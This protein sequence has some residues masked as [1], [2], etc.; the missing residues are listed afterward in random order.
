M[1]LYTRQVLGQYSPPAGGARAVGGSGNEPGTTSCA[2]RLTSGLLQVKRWIVFFE[3]S[4]RT[5]RA[6]DVFQ[7]L[8][9]QYDVPLPIRYHWMEM[10]KALCPHHLWMWWGS[11][12]WVGT[13]AQFLSN[14]FSS[15]PIRLGSYWTKIFGRKGVGRKW[16]GRK[17]GLPSGDDVVR[18]ISSPSVNVRRKSAVSGC[19][20]LRSWST[21][22]LRCC[23]RRATR[24]AAVQDLIIS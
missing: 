21:P 2:R 10:T 9:S 5:K 23:M 12:L 22:C 3:H 14:T 4:F 16:I 7:V 18:S 20:L 19:D 24:L 8:P 17:V 13:C 6:R 1:F 15:N 11:R